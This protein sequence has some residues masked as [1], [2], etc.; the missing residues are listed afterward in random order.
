M[1]LPN[2]LA[3]IGE[4]LAKLPQVQIAKAI[5]A[6]VVVYMAYLCAQITWQLMPNDS[7]QSPINAA[8]SP[9]VASST[10]QRFDLAGFQSL[11]LFGDYQQTDEVQLPE[12]QDAPET[13][14]NLTLAGVVASSDAKT[15]AAIIENNGAQE[16]YGI[17]DKITG[18]RAQLAQVHAD[19][20]IIKQGGRM[21]TLMLDGF[22]YNKNNTAT[23]SSSST[24]KATSRRSQTNSPRKTNKKDTLDLRNNKALSQV[25]KNIKQ[26][27]ADNPGK[28]ADYLRIPPK[29]MQ[30]KIVGYRLMPGK[31]AEFFKSSGLKSGDVAVQMNGLDLTQPSEAAQALKALK[32]DS[33]ISL[34]VDRRGELTEILFSIANQ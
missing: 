9:Q 8:S 30:G 32:Q 27:I 24:N 17:G 15:A 21:E 12:V 13:N 19:R 10:Q 29:R 33:D 3:S 5:S 1:Q 20:V 7:A 31:Q 16:T 25:V 26:D 11:N 28:I 14:L 23:H 18:T 2:N 4:F 34:L 6:V 22:D